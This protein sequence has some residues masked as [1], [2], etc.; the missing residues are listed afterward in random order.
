QENLL[1][2]THGRGQVIEVEVAAERDGRIRGMRCRI[3]A[4]L[5]AYLVFTTAIVPTLTPLMIQGPYDIPA[6]RCELVAL[7]TNT[8]HT[9]AYRGAGRPEATYYLERVID[10]VAAE[11]KVDT[12]VVR[13]RNFIAT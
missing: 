6:L 9:C 5:G 10:L 1:T 2:T 3:L 8:C 7:Y 11:T 4:D 13:R 12:Y